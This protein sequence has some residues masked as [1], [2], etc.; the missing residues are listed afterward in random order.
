MLWP[1]LRCSAPFIPS[2]P[3]LPITAKWWARWIP[4]HPQKRPGRIWSRSPPKHLSLIHICPG[5]AI[6][7]LVV[8]LIAALVLVGCMVAELVLTWKSAA[9]FRSIRIGGPPLPEPETDEIQ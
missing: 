3:P 9:F 2:A 5:V 1:P 8:F 4:G 7:L 6:A